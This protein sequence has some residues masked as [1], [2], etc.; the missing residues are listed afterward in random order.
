MK[1]IYEP[2]GLTHGQILSTT[3]LYSKLP[4]TQGKSGFDT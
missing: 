4:T 1:R 3:V 2:S